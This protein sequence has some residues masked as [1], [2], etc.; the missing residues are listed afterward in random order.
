MSVYFTIRRHDAG[1]L[2]AGSPDS[3]ADE[4][5]EMYRE[6]MGEMR[7]TRVSR[8]GRRRAD[9]G[10]GMARVGLI[11]V[12]MARVGLIRVGLAMALAAACWSILGPGSASAQD[13]GAWA[14]RRS[15]ATRRTEVGGAV[16]DGRLH[17]VGR[18]PGSVAP[19]GA[20]DAYHP[21]T[22][23]WASLAPLPSDLH[24]VGVV[25]V[26]GR[27]YAV[28]GWTPGLVPVATTF[29]YD[30]TD[31]TWR[32]RAPLPTARASL[33]VIASGGLIYAI[34]GNTGSGGAGDAG[35]VEAYDP[36]ADHWEPL[37]PLPTPR[38]HAMGGDLGG[39]LHVV[40]GRS[41]PG[42]LLMTTHEAFDPATRAWTTLPPLPTG[43]SGG[44][45]TVQD[46]RLHVLGGEGG[47][48]TFWTHEA[49]EP[50]SRAWAALPPM[51]TARHGL[52]VGVV[53]GVL[54]AAS[55]GPMPGATFS[56]VLE[57][58]TPSSILEP[59]AEPAACSSRPPVRVTAVR[60]ATGMLD[61]T[62]RATTTAALADNAI[63]A[64]R[65]D[66]ATNADVELVGYAALAER[67]TIR[68]APA[69]TEAR[70]RVR[71]VV[72]GRAAHVQLVASDRCGPWP[73]FVGGGAAAF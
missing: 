36:V 52:A 11:R 24:H 25:A 43:R 64:V 30:P 68:L 5:H 15:L 66:R 56:D 37:P 48:A 20:H 50:I 42:G 6:A 65:L 13:G 9:V 55:G 72:A 18:Y 10:C 29:E 47:P 33:V 16:L 38:H 44:A 45:A 8:L 14:D 7:D 67:A 51:P 26:G 23:T 61:V 69:S 40:G 2:A 53:D 17:V 60:G 4:Y 58:F 27:L 73:T 19:A 31:D 62:I 3:L 41:V 70:L 63:D 22:D 21:G 28:G 57:A 12:G 39:R 49:Y 1:F 46:G 34:G 71:R 54:Y 59:P 32:P 35:A